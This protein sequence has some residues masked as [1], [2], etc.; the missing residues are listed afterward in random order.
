MRAFATKLE[1][2]RGGDD[3]QPFWIAWNFPRLSCDWL[4]I[5][6]EYFR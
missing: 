2:L 5:D 4:E 3:C 6:G 1:V